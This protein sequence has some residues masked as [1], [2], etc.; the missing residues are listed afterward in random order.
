MTRE[1]PSKRS[2]TLL[3]EAPEL[4]CFRK[5]DPTEGQGDALKNRL[6]FL[7]MQHDEPETLS[8]AEREYSKIEKKF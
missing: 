3:M 1:M 5:G 2:K 8:L 7:L 4:N 6:D